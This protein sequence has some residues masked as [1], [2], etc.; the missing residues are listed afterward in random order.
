MTGISVRKQAVADIATLPVAPFVEA[1]S[2]PDV[3]FGSNVFEIG[4]AH[5]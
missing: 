3:A 1:E 5:V 4:R 2:T